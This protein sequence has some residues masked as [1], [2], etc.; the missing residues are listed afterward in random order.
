MLFDRNS[1]KTAVF[2]ARTY[3]G[4]PLGPK[5]FIFIE[6]AARDA[7]NKLVEEQQ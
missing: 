2:V 3:G 5:R 4:I 1:T 6:K 7:L